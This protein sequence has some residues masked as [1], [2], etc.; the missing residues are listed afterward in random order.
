MNAAVTADSTANTP[1]TSGPMAGDPQA[2]VGGDRYPV[3]NP[4]TFQYPADY[5]ERLGRQA[6]GP[7]PD[8]NGAGAGGPTYYGP[9]ASGTRPYGWP[10]DTARLQPRIEP[11][12]MR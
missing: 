7:A 3:T 10:P 1:L 4:A 8:I 9:T 5:H 2:S 12:P 11:P 6:Q